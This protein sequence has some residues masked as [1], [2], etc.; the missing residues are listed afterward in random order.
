MRARRPESG[1]AG[2]G[3]V[4]RLR[5]GCVAP[6]ASAGFTLLELLTVVFIIAILMTIFFS[7]YGVIRD[8]AEDSTCTANLRTLRVSFEAYLQ[9][10][11][12]W[13]QPPGEGWEDED[14]MWEFWVTELEP[15]DGRQKYWVCPTDRRYFLQSRSL[16]DLPDYYGSYI[17]TPFDAA[18]ATPYR[19]RQPWLLERGDFHGKGPKAMMPDGSILTLPSGSVQGMQ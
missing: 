17:P 2:Q 13:P 4:S 9:D 18:E 19:W 15:Y 1:A 12:R 3:L 10:N 8:K 6:S 5:P 16:E 14:K 11:H 7:L